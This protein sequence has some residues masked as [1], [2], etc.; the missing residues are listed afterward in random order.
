MAFVFKETDG[1]SR[2]PSSDKSTSTIGTDNS[3]TNLKNTKGNTETT[4]KGE[5]AGSTTQGAFV[6]DASQVIQT[7]ISQEFNVET[8]TKG[9]N[10]LSPY[11]ARMDALHPTESDLAQKTLNSLQ[12]VTPSG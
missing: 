4:N 10:A 1:T 6:C 9:F 5:S 12:D 2:K 3:K 7:R 8:S 11:L